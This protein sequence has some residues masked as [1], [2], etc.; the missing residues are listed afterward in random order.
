MCH[1]FQTRVRARLIWW[2]VA[3]VDAAACS[4]PGGVPEC[5][6]G[7]PHRQRC[8]LCMTLGQRRTISFIE[9]GCACAR[10]RCHLIH[11]IRGYRAL[12]SMRDTTV[13]I[14][15]LKSVEF[16]LRARLILSGRIV[17]LAITATKWTREGMATLAGCNVAAVLLGQPAAAGTLIYPPGCTVVLRSVSI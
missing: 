2:G 17:L 3:L 10:T 16:S 11:L 15:H 14:F 13:H 12:S 7:T 8:V 9:T 1:P 6:R 5:N 4:R